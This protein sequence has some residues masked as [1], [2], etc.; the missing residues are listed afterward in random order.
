MRGVPLIVV[1]RGRKP[2]ESTRKGDGLNMDCVSYL[3]KCDGLNMD[4]VSYLKDY[5]RVRGHLR[6]GDTTNNERLEE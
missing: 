5:I 3:N 4:C 6:I 1:G 2:R